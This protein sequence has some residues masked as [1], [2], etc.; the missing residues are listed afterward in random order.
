VSGRHIERACSG[1]TQHQQGS[2]HF[3]KLLVL[4]RVRAAC[5]GIVESILRRKKIKRQRGVG[6]AQRFAVRR[7]NCINAI[8]AGH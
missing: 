4:P 1:Q 2:F 3:C 8:P 7:K 5:L 6:G